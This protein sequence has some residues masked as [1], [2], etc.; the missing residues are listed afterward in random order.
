M[1]PRAVQFTKM[2]GL[3]NDFIVVEAPLALTQTMIR[4]LA[5]RR[6]GIGF[7]QLLL[8]EPPSAAGIDADVR[9]F[10]A[11]G[12]EV[13]QCGNGMRCVARF[14]ADGKRRGRRLNL[15]TAAGTMRAELLEDGQVS[16]AM[17]QPWLDPADIP[18]LAEARALRYNLDIGDRRVE[19]GAL[20]MGNP[21]AVVDIA[22]MVSAPVAEL[23]AAIGNHPRFPER[24]NVG[25]LERRGRNRIG[26]RVFERGVGETLAC[27]SGACAAVVW[28]RLNGWLG[29]CVEVMLPGGVLV[30][31]WRGEGNTVW[32]TGP[33]TRVFDGVIRL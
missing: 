9:I 19:I 30:V 1:A 2:E 23:G 29:E 24:A 3:G 25:F 26:L 14:L 13:E 12:G 33:A 5:D 16:I 31:S 27:G 8:I 11:D 20:S 7:D 22:G 18:F 32:L 21:H 10:N 28:G 17:G 4:R 6:R 15:K